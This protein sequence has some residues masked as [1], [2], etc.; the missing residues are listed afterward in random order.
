[1]FAALPN[2]YNS[3][4]SNANIP[5]KDDP[6]PFRLKHYFYPAPMNIFQDGWRQPLLPAHMAPPPHAG[7]HMAY[8]QAPPPPSAYSPLQIQPPRPHYE[9]PRE[10]QP[11]ERLQEQQERRRP[12]YTRYN[13]IGTQFR[14]YQ[15]PSA[16]RRGD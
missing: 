5:P 14:T 15:G 11:H 4:P 8:P 9:P 7:P 10:E 6:F 1:M 12:Q 16:R 3:P 13:A 2:L